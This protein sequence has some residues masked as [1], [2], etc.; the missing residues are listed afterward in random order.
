MAQWWTC[1]CGSWA[2]CGN[3]AYR[4]C[5]AACPRWAQPNSNNNTHLAP[6]ASEAIKAAAQQLLGQG[7]RGSASAPTG[8]QRSKSKP[9][10]GAQHSAKPVEPPASPEAPKDPPVK[11]K[12]I[13]DL[14]E[15]DL[16]QM[17]RLNKSCPLPC[18]QQVALELQTE[19]DR[20]AAVRHEAKPGWAQLQVAERL[21][22]RRKAALDK[23]TEDHGAATK[24]YEEAKAA[25]HEAEQKVE[26]ARTLHDEAVAAEKARRQ[27]LASAPPLAASAVTLTKCMQALKE[28][29]PLAAQSAF[30]AL[31]L[32][33][34]AHS[35]DDVE[36]ADAEPRP[37][38][39]SPEVPPVPAPA[40]IQEDPPPEA[41]PLQNSSAPVDMAR[42]VIE[43]DRLSLSLPPIVAKAAAEAEGCLTLYA[44]LPPSPPQRRPK[45]SRSPRP[46]RPSYDSEGVM[47]DTDGCL[48]G[49]QPRRRS[50]E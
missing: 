40:P 43:A 28:L 8:K 47:T 22:A 23:R 36:M 18:A 26:A 21:T 41:P 38:D 12:V 48:V 10:T 33:L 50:A 2:Y 27:E 15:E 3:R 16:R 45:R 30:E 29:L 14:P 7:G 37:A 5:G 13:A 19:L 9:T 32:A 20:R 39:P 1:R 31:C 42:A 46:S 35:P 6:W 25:L 11:E 44:P 34:A 49:Q 24:V 4:S 17:L